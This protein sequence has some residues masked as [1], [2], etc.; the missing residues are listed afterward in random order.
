MTTRQ[1]LQP[2][3][4]AVSAL[5]L[6]VLASLLSIHLVITP[7][8]THASTR[9]AD[10]I[11]D[12]RAS[13]QREHELPI[14]PVNI[15]PPPIIDPAD[16]KP[17]APDDPRAHVPAD[18]AL[19][20]LSRDLPVPSVERSTTAPRDALHHYVD[21][22]L[23]LVER[24]TQD[25]IA[26]F[27]LAAKADPNAPEIWACLADAYRAASRESDAAR[28]LS[29]AVEL[30]LSTPNA[31]WF[32][33]KDAAIARIVP[34]AAH[35]LLRA[36]ESLKPGS[37]PA[38]SHLI[39]FDA[40]QLLEGQSYLAAARDQLSL[41]LDLPPP[42][43]FR[44]EFRPEIAEVYRRSAELTVRQGDLSL[45]L[46]DHADALN[47]YAKAA[48]TPG[49]DQGQA[50]PRL[51]LANL[52]AGRPNSAA[53][54]LL[55][56]ITT[57][58]SPIT[59][60]HEALA[61]Y[62]ARHVPDTETFANAIAQAARDSQS[63]PNAKRSASAAARA[64]I[65]AAAV[66]SRPQ[67]SA[68]L[69]IALIANPDDPALAVAFLR[70]H[71]VDDS[72]LVSAAAADPVA[73]ADDLVA[74]TKSSPEHAPL[75]ASITAVQGV[76]L[77]SILRQL[78]SRDS[79]DAAALSRLWLL[80][81]LAMDRLALDEALAR[82]W[83]KLFST[84]ATYAQ[85]RLADNLA[86]RDT[87]ATAID[88]LKS[89]DT[90]A[91]RRL[92][93]QMLQRR[94]EFAA[95]ADAVKPLAE[96][97]DPALADLLIYSS[98]LALDGST[99]DAKAAL[100]RA[101]ALDPADDRPREALITILSTP[102]TQSQLLDAARD[103]RAASPSS[104]LLRLLT[105]RDLISRNLVDQAEQPLFDLA[106]SDQ[107]T[108][109]VYDLLA[110]LAAKAARPSP[111]I[112]DRAELFLRDLR[113]RRPDSAPITSAL[114]VTLAADS[115]DAAKA[116]EA[117]SLLADFTARFP[118]P[119]LQRLRERIIRDRLADSAAADALQLERLTHAPPT[120]ENTLEHIDLLVRTNQLKDLPAV[121]S[122]ALA[123]RD[124]LAPAQLAV[125]RSLITRIRVFEGKKAVL[126][127]A[128][129]AAL[130]DALDA[131]AADG[132]SRDAELLR[133]QATVVGHPDDAKRLVTAIHA[134][135]IAIPDLPE[136]T[137]AEFVSQAL[138]FQSKS[139]SLLDFAQA[140]F[141]AEPTNET[142][143]YI[144]FNA[145]ATVGDHTDAKRIAD[146]LSGEILTT[147][148]TLAQ[149]TPGDAKVL[150]TVDQRAEVVYGLA[151]FMFANTREQAALDTLRL[152]LE[153]NPRHALALNDLGY[154][155]LESKEHLDE[156]AD[157]I[158]RAHAASPNDH[159]IVDSLAWLRY[160]QGR[161]ADT[162]EGPGAITLLRRAAK[163]AEDENEPN[164]EVLGHLG[165]ALW[166]SG[167]KDAA[168]KAW[169][170]AAK[171]AQPYISMFEAP[172]PDPIDPDPE[173]QK[174]VDMERARRK[175]FLEE[176]RAHALKAAD[177]QAGREPQ[178]PPQILLPKA[179]SP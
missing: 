74:L 115:T 152:V 171:L 9:A 111:A 112:R 37:D 15:E 167:E 129:A 23:A 161:L 123:D 169:R 173:Q 121:V 104:R 63:T 3:R 164:P 146:T 62:L 2:T 140:L 174:L 172:L 103:L 45:R 57:S 125:L 53:I 178:L 138:L 4:V 85:A 18:D 29:R 6:L 87:R 116:R 65:L 130:A 142:R 64:D 42:A 32:L 11:A 77:E 54:S 90:P 81:A 158:E 136:D 59:D 122:T 139:R 56:S 92:L 73:I 131:L 100:N 144:W 49:L 175:K 160:H 165:D 133:L 102:A 119:E 150:S 28:A 61:F 110:S 95:A 68:I 149:A 145:I 50:L 80:D 36:R 108:P 120:T 113:A 31:H 147:A 89:I 134:A 143:L 124:A 148:A 83:S 79:D 40:A 109:G 99:N 16:I 88:K 126:Q 22:R 72:S 39:A 38:L 117:E 163:L 153:Y 75:Y 127:P 154:N 159:H 12:I 26:E 1:G 177:A 14:T 25:A 135:A 97:D 7:R 179:P 21:A 155:L 19:A 27:Q 51:V 78:Q 137:L 60:R 58:N 8:L 170:D 44:T 106:A 34:L 52:R 162:P 114:A 141:E 48:T 156:A 76:A 82:D 46:G 41:A 166:R 10:P 107:A 30:G 20:E 71:A 17:V 176:Y 70:L 94:R 5:V 93:A 86:E 105:I 84:A 24:R 55:D 69:K 33:A 67:A 96:R 157:A 118:I 151:R 101:I 43:Q 35:H 98:S 132:L 13:A 168:I 128:Q 66:A 47:A 91:G